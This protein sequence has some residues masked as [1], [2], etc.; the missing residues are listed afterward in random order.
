MVHIIV[1]SCFLVLYK[2]ELKM[3]R[4]LIFKRKT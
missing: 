1:G 4:E 3:F 2:K